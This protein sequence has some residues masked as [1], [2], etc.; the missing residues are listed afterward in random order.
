MIKSKREEKDVKRQRMRIRK[1]RMGE[2]D[3]ESTVT[4]AS[5]ISGELT[6]PK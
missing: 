4:R 3:A 6:Y 1:E 5:N 2:N